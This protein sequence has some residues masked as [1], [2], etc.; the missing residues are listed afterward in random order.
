MVVMGDCKNKEALV[1][2]LM[3]TYALELKHI[4]FL[5]VNDLTESEDIVQEVFLSC[6]KR[7]DDFRQEASY[8]TWIIRMTINKCKDYKK[9]W[10]V[11]NLF[12]FAWVTP[13][14]SMPSA[15]SLHLEEVGVEK[16]VSA[17]AKLPSKYKDV[18]IL[19]YY[20]EM[21]MQEI[22]DVLE[23]PASTVKSRVKRAKELL[24]ERLGG[25]VD[26]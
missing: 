13:R 6:Y 24:G 12:Y 16:I 7:L 9:R 8:K 5:Y 10:N 3:Q 17:I 22:S 23:V 18:I 20:E 14:E 1:E 19:Y 25:D 11:R 21:K 4:A 15:E 26:E 2:Q